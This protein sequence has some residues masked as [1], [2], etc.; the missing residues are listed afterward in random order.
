MNQEIY[1]LINQIN[2]DLLN[3]HYVPKLTHLNKGIGVQGLMYY[4]G[5]PPPKKEQVRFLTEEVVPH[6]VDAKCEVVLCADAT[7]FK[8][9]T[10]QAKADAVIGYA[11]D[12]VF[13]SF[14]VIYLPHYKGLFY[15]P[16]EVGRKID[17]ALNTCSTLLLGS[18]REPGKD[19]IKQAFYPKSLTEIED[20]L[21]K[22]LAFPTLSVDIEAFGLKHYNAGIGTITFCWDQHHGI[23]FPV[24]YKSLGSTKAP[25]GEEVRNEPVRKLLR[26]F[27]DRYKGN[28]KYHNIAYDA[29][30]L[31]YQL[32]MDDLLDT[33][34]LLLGLDTMLVNWDCTKIISYLATNT[35][36]GNKLSLK[37]Q[38][39]EFA[40]NYSQ[41][42]IKDIR[43]IPLDTLLEYNLV[44]GL[45][46]HYT[47]NKNYPI[48]VAD[49][50]LDIYQ[51]LFKQATVDIIQMQLTGLPLNM[52]KVV[53]AEKL[54]KADCD[55]ALLR[56][57]QTKT[58]MAFTSVLHQ[59]YVDAKNAS[60]KKKRIGLQDAIDDGIVFNPDSGPQLV[61]LLY[62]LLEL[63]VLSTTDTGLPSADGTT[64]EDLQNHT[65]D[66]DI[67]LFLKALLDYKAV[68]KILSAFIPHMLAAPKAKDGWHYLY[69]NFNLGGT[70]SGRL[71]SSK[72]NLQ[73][74]PASGSKY[75]KIIKECFEAIVGWVFCGLDFALI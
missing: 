52:E 73:Q 30:V 28:I 34:G 65:D 22:L 48:M 49:D 10:G 20:W 19:I 40:G 35:C 13:G 31:I 57:S 1:I 16:E 14:K 75:A 50:Q 3:K 43:N 64:I 46:T 39:Q 37:E 54:L 29:Y 71:S 24:D 5:K 2:T 17:V 72:I 61:K 60:Y 12:S 18:Y 15:N 33:E 62:E 42:E 6:L 55:D 74:L 41:D 68:S 25:Y 23:A 11:L 59:D 45:A 9:L 7:Y 36:A 69:G 44:D 70:V 21:E 38:A 67:L 8:T 63:P 56:M 27:F 4:K 58:V 66:P 47:Y 32:Y 51:N 26:S 53:L